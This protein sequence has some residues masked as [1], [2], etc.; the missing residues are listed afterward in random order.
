M[1]CFLSLCCPPYLLRSAS[2][3]FCSSSI[4]LLRSRSSSCRKESTLVSSRSFLSSS[5]ETQKP[6]SQY[7]SLTKGKHLRGLQTSNS[8]ASSFSLT[9]Q[10]LK[11]N[12]L[13]SKKYSI[14]IYLSPVSHSLLP[15]RWFRLVSGSWTF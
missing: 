2:F 5:S 13:I 8:F 10:H 9:E 12:T 1:S 14:A 7:S 4:L 15:P 6:G 3:I 11:K